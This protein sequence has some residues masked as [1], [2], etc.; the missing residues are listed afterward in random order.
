M[1]WPSG[2]AKAGVN[3]VTSRGASPD[4]IDYRAY[5]E[6]LS[7]AE[8]DRL[9]VALTPRLTPYIHQSPTPPQAAFLLADELEVLFG[10]AAGPGKSSGLLMA[11]LQYVDV[12]GYAALLLRRTYKDL[13]LPGAL[14]DRSDQWLRSTDA[15]WSPTEMTWVF[16]SGATLTFG[17]LNYE[18][19]KYQYQSAEFQFVGFDELTQFS[20]TQYLY[21]FSRLRR[22][23]G[24]DV[25]I[26]MRT[27]SNPGGAGHSW[28][29]Q[30]FI[31][32]HSP[33]RLYIPARLRD[34]P[35]LDAD[36]YVS[37][38]QQL[39]PVTRA[40]YLDGD[41]TI[42]HE[43]RMFSRAWF[44][45]IDIAPVGLRTVRRWDLASTSKVEGNDP[46][47][48]AGAKMSVDAQGRYYLLDVVRERMTPQGVERLIAN[49]AALDGPEV[50]IVIEEE[51]GSSGKALVSYYQRMVL[52]RYAVRGVRMTGDKTTRAAPFASQAEAGNVSLVRGSWN[53]AWLDEAE[54]FPLGDHDDQLDAS[55]GAWESLSG[56]GNARQTVY[57][58][59]YKEPVSRRGDLVLK[60]ERYVD[61]TTRSR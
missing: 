10:G 46:D 58:T 16:P 4:V 21:L 25:P 33:D 44:P 35:Y 39:D 40:R 38:L 61:K 32:S 9:F 29:R 26:R 53:A 34:N 36:S 42:E 14:L 41:W 37:S 27:A 23:I 15:R 2:R 13:S 49:T 5:V 1:A 11:A 50:P 18:A 30:R 47:W 31:D 19:D 52:P 51:P 59:P 12:P 28:V 56:S 24:S 60:G 55:V 8:R 22:L 17:H 7:P 57:V 43:G 48:T 45:I 6:S 20:E 3:I 54:M